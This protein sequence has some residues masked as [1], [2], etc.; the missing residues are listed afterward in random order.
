MP[1]MQVCVHPEV[2]SG[3][4]FTA[5][6]DSMEHTC[7]VLLCMFGHFR[8]SYLNTVGQKALNFRDSSK[9]KRKIHD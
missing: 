1:N 8:W 7:G 3:R 2:P 9:K 5:G 4:P 6:K